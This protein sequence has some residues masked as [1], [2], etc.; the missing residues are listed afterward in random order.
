MGTP[1]AGAVIDLTVAID[2]VIAAVL[3]V[4]GLA[5]RGIRVAHDCTIPLSTFGAT[6]GDRWKKFHGRSEWRR[7][8]RSGPVRRLIR[9]FASLWSRMSA[10]RRGAAVDINHLLAFLRRE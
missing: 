9:R 10:S 3:G 7:R 4:E 5:G 8:S 1:A 2:G 6:T